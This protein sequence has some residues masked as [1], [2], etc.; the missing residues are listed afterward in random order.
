MRID[1]F[2]SFVCSGRWQYNSNLALGDDD[3]LLARMLKLLSRFPSPTKA[4]AYLELNFKKRTWTGGN[5]PAPYTTSH[6]VCIASRMR[7][8]STWV[9]AAFGKKPNPLWCYKVTKSDMIHLYSCWLLQVTLFWNL[10]GG[11]WVVISREKH[12]GEERRYRHVCSPWSAF[13]SGGGREP[14]L[15]RGLEGGDWNATAECQTL[16][17]DGIIT[18]SSKAALHN[19]ASSL[20]QHIKFKKQEKLN[21]NESHQESNLE[22]RSAPLCI[23][24]MLKNNRP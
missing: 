9:F 23:V 24:N 10:S 8:K 19:S 3:T 16:C 13:A 7:K 5:F 21:K 22:N 12:K 20:P 18:D 11:S 1:W 14:C 6:L 17:P 2:T 15:T 4:V